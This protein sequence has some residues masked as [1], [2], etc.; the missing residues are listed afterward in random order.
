VEFGVFQGENQADGLFEVKPKMYR[1]GI[2]VQYFFSTAPRQPQ[3]YLTFGAALVRNK[4]GVDY[5]DV[6]E[7]SDNGANSVAGAAG[8]GV[9]IGSFEISGVYNVN[10]VG[11]TRFIAGVED[12]AWDWAVLRVGVA[13]PNRY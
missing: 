12:H 3:V 1:Y 10:R 8:L 13:L 4:L 6:G 5:L 2:D 9:R 7:Y 11:T